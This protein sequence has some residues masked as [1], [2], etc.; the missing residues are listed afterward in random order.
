MSKNPNIKKALGNSLNSF[1]VVTIDKSGSCQQALS[2]M[3]HHRIHHLII[4]ENNL[5]VG[6]LTDRDMLYKSYSSTD[7]LP[8]ALKNLSIDSVM[9]RKVPIIDSKT[10]LSET[11]EEMDALGI[12]AVLLRNANG[13]WGI[14]TETDL[15]RLLNKLVHKLN[16]KKTLVMETETALASPVLQK[17]IEMANQMGI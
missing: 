7:G 2:L 4:T 11:L 10:T 3:I 14:I 1:P 5:P 9:R 8:T 17:L 12:S 13:S 15:L 16:W 6:I